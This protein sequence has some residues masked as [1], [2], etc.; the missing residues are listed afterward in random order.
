MNSNKNA[1]KKKRECDF[2]Y[3]FV[4]ITGGVP[5]LLWAR[6]K[7]YHISDGKLIKRKKIKGGV[8]ICSNHIAFTDPLFL[9]CV[10]WYRRVYFLA[11]QELFN[12]PLKRFFFNAVKCIPVDR[13]NFSMATFHT[14]T[15][16]LKNGKAVLI[17]PE[18]QV[19][20]NEN[21]ILAFKSGAVLMAATSS[22]PVLPVYMV[23]RERWYR[24][25]VVLIGDP[26]DL[27][28]IYG[29]RPSM[30][31]MREAS[32]LLHRKEEE[33]MRYYNEHIAKERVKN[34]MEI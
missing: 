1:S 20:R 28:A 23:K 21:E 11:M 30:Q 6:Q 16:R 19:N 3:N 2:F 7:V 22:T 26:I 27:T 34:E 31:S 10:F 29:E 13:S 18:G 12:T 33:L 5:A 15:D 32:E 17:F 4:K 8:L 25:G 24:R 9:N 14:V